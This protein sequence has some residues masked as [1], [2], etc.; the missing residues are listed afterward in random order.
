MSRGIKESIDSEVHL[1]LSDESGKLL[2]EDTGRN[3]G[4]EIMDEIFR[5]I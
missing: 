2:Y 1:Q 3:V 4:L 5:Y